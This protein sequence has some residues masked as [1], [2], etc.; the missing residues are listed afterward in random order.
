M[1]IGAERTAFFF[2]EERFPKTLD[3][4]ASSGIL[5]K[6]LFDMPTGGGIR[7]IYIVT[8]AAIEL[9]LSMTMPV[10]LLIE[11]EMLIYALSAMLF[12]YAFVY[13]RFQR[14]K[15][16]SVEGTD[17]ERTAL[18]GSSDAAALLS[19]DVDG[20][21]SDPT[22]YNIPGGKTACIA[23]MICP[24]LAFGAN[25]VLNLMDKGTTFFPYF[26]L[27]CFF[28]IIFIGFAAH[29]V[30]YYCVNKKKGN[31]YRAGKAALLD[32]KHWNN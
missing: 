25:T 10:G 27:V 26:K 4:W 22:V 24:V 32:G 13:L 31:S 14:E 1:V 29:A 6:I 21:K 16:M 3:R 18:F 9:L 19:L 17:A 12:F 30:S 11:L 7:R 20:K 28:G 2:C 5:G 23:I 8:V 15:R